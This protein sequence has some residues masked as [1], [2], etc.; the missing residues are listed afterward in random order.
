MTRSMSR[1]C[2]GVIACGQWEAGICCRDW[3]GLV[4][5]DSPS[6]MGHSQQGWVIYLT[7]LSLKHLLSFC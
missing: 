4:E 1:E 7:L 3:E 2:I 5:I 6:E